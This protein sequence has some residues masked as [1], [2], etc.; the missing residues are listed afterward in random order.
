MSLTHM[1]TRSIPTVSNFPAAAAT[2]T[3]VPTPSVPETRTGSRYFRAGK[4]KKPANEPISPSTSLRR[5]VRTIGRV[6]RTRRSPSSM[7]TPAVLYV[8]EFLKMRS[9]WSVRHGN[10]SP[11]GMSMILTPSQGKMNV[12]EQGGMHGDESGDRHPRRR[13]AEGGDQGG[14]PRLHD[15]AAGG[16][17]GGDRTVRDPSG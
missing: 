11:A 10:D 1:A 2:L 15:P 8:R 4:R 16:M 3:F 6:R 17:G 14:E 7:S 9:G 12:F 13:G 5:A